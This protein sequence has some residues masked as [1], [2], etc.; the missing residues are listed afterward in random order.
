MTKETMWTKEALIFVYE[1]ELG[2]C[3]ATSLASFFMNKNLSCLYVQTGNIM[4][5]GRVWIV[6]GEPKKHHGVLAN[7]QIYDAE[8]RSIQEN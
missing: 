6:G 4:S 1:T 7:S 2:F 5:D 3:V 8:S